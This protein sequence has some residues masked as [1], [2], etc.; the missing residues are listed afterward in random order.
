MVNPM[1]NRGA[2]SGTSQRLYECELDGTVRV[3]YEDTWGGTHEKLNTIGADVK[4]VILDIFVMTTNGVPAVSNT[5]VLRDLADATERYAQADIRIQTG[6]VTQVEMP[7]NVATNWHVMDETVMVNPRT[8]YLTM[9]AKTVLDTL[10][11]TTGHIGVVYVHGPLCGLDDTDSCS[12]VAIAE[13]SFKRSEDV[14]Y[15][16]YLFISSFDPS[17]FTLAHEGGHILINEGHSLDLWDLMYEFGNADK[18]VKRPKRLRSDKV[19]IMRGS[20]YIQ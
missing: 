12:G 8:Y 4:T 20:P 5:I 2:I 18:N 13:C 7:S 19:Q 15:L 10:Q 9:A 17:V 6:L 3:R 11:R 1:R 14:G 16:G